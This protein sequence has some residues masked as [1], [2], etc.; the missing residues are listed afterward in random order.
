MDRKLIRRRSVVAS[1]RPEDVWDPIPEYVLPWSSIVIAASGPSL[2]IEQAELVRD[3]RD[4]KPGERFI[5]A[6]NS[7]WELLRT[8]DFLYASDLSWWKH[9]KGA[10]DFTGV[11]I[12]QSA[13]AARDWPGVK[14]VRCVMKPGLSTTPA[15]IHN[16]RNSGF[17]AINLVKLMGFA[18]IGLVGFDM[19]FGPA[20]EVHHHGAHK[21][22][23]NPQARTFPRWLSA[24]EEISDE[25]IGAVNIYNCTTD[26]H[27]TRFD[28]MELT[29]FLKPPYVANFDNL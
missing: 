16:G 9:H 21:Y 12:T 14:F 27:L 5:M 4:E 2:T 1:L 8:A 28:R 18:R 20:G 7:T 24:F 26:T 10:E 6:V 3:W 25:Q 22:L 15:C 29:E 23:R 11:R 17:Q 19:K 13:V